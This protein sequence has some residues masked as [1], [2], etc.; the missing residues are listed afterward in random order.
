MKNLLTFPLAAVLLF[1]CKP[2]DVS[3][4]KPDFVAAPTALSFSACPTKD[5]NGLAVQG[6]FP[7]IKKFTITNQGKVSGDLG[8]TITGAGGTWQKKFTL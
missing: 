3:G 5:E 7:E 2:P 4:T 6:V 1:G 8:L